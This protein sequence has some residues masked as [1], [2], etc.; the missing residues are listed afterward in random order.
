MTLSSG[1]LALAIRESSLDLDARLGQQR[2]GASHGVLNAF[3]GARQAWAPST[4][5]RPEVALR[6]E[7]VGMIGRQLEG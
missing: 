1:K 6:L 5:P 7:A 2:V 3:F 4:T